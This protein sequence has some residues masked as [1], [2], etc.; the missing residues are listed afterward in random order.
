MR[1][2]IIFI[3]SDAS[4]VIPKEFVTRLF[5]KGMKQKG[6]SRYHIEVEAENEKEAINK[7]NENN[8]GYLDSLRELSGSAVICSVCVIIMALIYL[9]R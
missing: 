8:E 7:L 1:K 6:F 4:K 2:Y 3:K 5:I 9:L